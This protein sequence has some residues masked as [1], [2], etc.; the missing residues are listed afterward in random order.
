MKFAVTEHFLCPCGFDAAVS[1]CGTGT[2]SVMAEI[3]L[4]Q[5]S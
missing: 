2:F 5:M 1:V 3:E 4:L